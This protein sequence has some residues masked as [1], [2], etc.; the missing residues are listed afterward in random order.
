M[1]MGI[2]GVTAKACQAAASG[3][4]SAGSEPR[5]CPGKDLA[6]YASPARNR[7]PRTPMLP[8]SGDPECGCTLQRA[9]QL[10]WFPAMSFAPAP[11]PHPRKAPPPDI[12]AQTA[13]T[14]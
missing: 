2:T 4:V 7:A 12:I 14:V 3:A 8:P 6:R 9:A 13:R 10:R 5:N 11:D 1:H